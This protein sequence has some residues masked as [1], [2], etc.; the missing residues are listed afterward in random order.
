MPAPRVYAW[1]Q[2]HTFLEGKPIRLL[3]KPVQYR[4]VDVATLKQLAKD[5][6]K[7]FGEFFWQHLSEIAVDQ[8]GVFAGTNDL[9][10]SIGGKPPMTLEAFVEKH[11]RELTA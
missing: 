3:G 4:Q 9:V 10:E 6:G 1:T 2:I 11:R 7:E 5:N 8:E